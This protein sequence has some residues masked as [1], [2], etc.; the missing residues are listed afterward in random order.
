MIFFKLVIRAPLANTIDI[1]HCYFRS[2][3]PANIQQQEASG[4][5]VMDFCEQQYINKKYFYARLH[6][7]HKQ[8]ASSGK[9]SKT[10]MGSATMSLQVSG[11]RLTVPLN[12]EP[13]WLAELLKGL[14]S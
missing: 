1:D 7:L 12:C 9:V 8:A 10:P 11:T 3:T 13:L 6:T 4:L 5:S 2:D 14:S